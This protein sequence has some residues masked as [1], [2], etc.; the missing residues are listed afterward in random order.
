MNEM[1]VEAAVAVKVVVNAFQFTTT[2]ELPELTAEYNGTELINTLTVLE[3]PNTPV[4]STMFPTEN[5]TLY[6]SPI[7]V[8]NVCATPVAVLLNPVRSS[9][10]NPD[11]ALNVNFPSA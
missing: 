10:C 6:V 5:A 7:V 2:P 1:V 8:S 3:E 4:E 11:V 9:D